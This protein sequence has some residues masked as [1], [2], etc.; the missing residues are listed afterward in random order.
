MQSVAKT[1]DYM[2][3]I[4]SEDGNDLISRADAIKKLAEFYD[5]SIRMVD[6]VTDLLNSLPSVS[7]ERVGEWIWCGDKGDSRFMCSVCKSKENVPTCM[8]EPSV[9]V[10]C[11]N[12][13]AKM[14]GGAE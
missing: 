2:Q 10:Y 13:G 6:E 11:P 5:Y 3:Q 9:W 12:C 8:G 7:A 4:P 1:P 14:K